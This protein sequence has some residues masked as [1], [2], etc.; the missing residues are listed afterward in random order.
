MLTILQGVNSSEASHLLG[1]GMM[2]WDS[3]PGDQFA[4]Q[5]R[6]AMPSCFSSLCFGS[7]VLRRITW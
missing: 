7:G 4:E 1:K 3:R 5:A 2:C 6:G